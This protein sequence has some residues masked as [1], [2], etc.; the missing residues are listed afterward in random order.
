MSRRPPVPDDD[1]ID[2]QKVRDLM[3]RHP[4]ESVMLI[5]TGEFP[6]GVMVRMLEER[7]RSR[8]GDKRR[9]TARLPPSR[10]R[11]RAAK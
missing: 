3:R 5:A 9:D 8:L 6:V 10:K 1:D 2:L 7:P 11:A 4:M